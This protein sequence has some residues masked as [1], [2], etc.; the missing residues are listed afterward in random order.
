MNIFMIFSKI[1][2][3]IIFIIF[4]MLLNVFKVSKMF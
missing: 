1:V 4:K 3:I 2:K